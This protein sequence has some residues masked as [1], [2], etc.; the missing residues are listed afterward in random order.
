MKIYQIEKNQF[1]LVFSNSNKKHQDIVY[2][3]KEKTDKQS[4]CIYV[5]DV[6]G[7]GVCV[8]DF[9]DN[10]NYNDSMSAVFSDKWNCYDYVIDNF[11]INS[12]ELMKINLFNRR[13]K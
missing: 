10:D 5:V 13:V 3:T 4:P 12:T 7:F 9:S 6:F 11:N 1:E 8:G 2:I